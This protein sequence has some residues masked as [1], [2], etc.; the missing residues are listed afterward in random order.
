TCTTCGGKGQVVMSSGFFR[1]A[2]T[3][4]TC[5]GQGQIITEY[6][7]KCNGK[8]ALRVTRMIDV[9][10]PPGVDNDSRLRVRGEG[11]VGAAGTGDLYLYVHVLPH[12]VF[13]RDGLDLYMQLPVSF[14]KAV[15]GG[16]VNVP[17]LGGEVSMTVP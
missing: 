14:I 8:G 16:E 13:Q 5:G 2:Q 11:E 4:S 12:D 9:N 10:I 15:L 17:T 7:P 1:M 3:C 6:C